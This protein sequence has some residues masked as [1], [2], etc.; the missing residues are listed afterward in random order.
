[1]IE[2][3]TGVNRQE[4]SDGDGSADEPGGRLMCHCASFRS[5]L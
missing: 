3:H 1:V 5:S 4:I 2:P